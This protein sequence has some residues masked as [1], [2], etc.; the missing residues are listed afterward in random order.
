MSEDESKRDLT[1][2]PDSLPLGPSASNSITVTHETL[3]LSKKV[4]TALAGFVFLLTAVT[5]S[6][7]ITY[8]VTLS[9]EIILPVKCVQENIKAVLALTWPKHCMGPPESRF[10][11]VQNPW[12][13]F[14]IKEKII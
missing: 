14:C 3:A 11:L 2:R 8:S 6:M 13:L 9:N 5:Y 1:A 7:L 12:V 10:D 4:N